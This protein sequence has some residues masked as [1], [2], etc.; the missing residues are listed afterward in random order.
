MGRAPTNDDDDDDNDDDVAVEQRI[1]AEN[2][3]EFV[4][5]AVADNAVA[6]DAAAAVDVHV[7]ARNCDAVL[8]VDQPQKPQVQ[9][10][11]PRAE[12]T[13]PGSNSS[14]VKYHHSLN[15]PTATAPDDQMICVANV[16][17]RSPS[18]RSSSSNANV[19]SSKRKAD[20][21][22]LDHYA[23]GA[24]A[25][26]AQM[27]ETPA[28]AAIVGS[29]IVK[30][31]RRVQSKTRGQHHPHSI[32]SNSSNSINNISCSSCSSSS[33]C[34]NSNCVGSGGGGDATTTTTTSIGTNYSNHNNQC[35]GNNPTSSNAGN[36]I[37]SST[38]KTGRNK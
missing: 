32:S 23:D 2:L 10:A 16:L 8:L 27:A 33:S 38:A 20:C 13:N 36:S 15:V 6:V 19:S 22:A 4:P 14:S 29:D 30:K 28:Q 31:A 3:E 37:G 24:D 17:L 21:A 5:L 1:D 9:T 18:S 12:H 11:D 34:C 26:N 7:D 25:A 35:V